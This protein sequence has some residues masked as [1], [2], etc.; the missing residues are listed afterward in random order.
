MNRY[1]KK[2][3][4]KLGV[5]MPFSELVQRIAQRDVI[6]PEQKIKKP[7]RKKDGANP[8]MRRNKA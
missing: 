5:N 3:G 7:K 8:P 2:K 6:G 1:G 4:A